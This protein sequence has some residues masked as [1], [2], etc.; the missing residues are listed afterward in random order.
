MNIDPYLG[1]HAAASLTH[2]EL[3]YLMGLAAVELA[4]RSDAAEY[5]DVAESIVFGPGTSEEAIE[6]I[7]NER[8][9]IA[10][11]EE[12]LLDIAAL[13]EVTPQIR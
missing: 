9:S 8:E 2:E 11:A 12:V 5:R 6:E 1:R 13:P 10:F 4:V 7:R 3:R